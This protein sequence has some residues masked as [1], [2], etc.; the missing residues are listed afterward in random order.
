MLEYE[1]TFDDLFRYI[2]LTNEQPSLRARGRIGDETWTQWADG[3]K[4]NMK[5]PVFARA[6]AEI[7]RMAP[8]Q[9]Q[10]LKRLLEED[11]CNDP[12]TWPKASQS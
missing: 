9:F 5:L 2:D 3:I 7:Q 8:T 12:K 10:E 1:K 6:W 4:F 11:F